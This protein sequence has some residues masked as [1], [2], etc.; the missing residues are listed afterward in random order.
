[1]DID[2]A[3]GNVAE[4]SGKTSVS[5]IWDK[6]KGIAEVAGSILGGLAT[7]VMVGMILKCALPAMVAACATRCRRKGPS[8]EQIELTGRATYH[9][10]IPQRMTRQ[11]PMRRH[12]FSDWNPVMES[13]PLVA[14]GPRLQRANTTR[15][16]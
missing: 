9:S 8:D 12:S 13:S 6:I 14:E 4:V 5:Q 15:Y 1:M 7:L 10:S 3:E 16:V 11:Q 2:R